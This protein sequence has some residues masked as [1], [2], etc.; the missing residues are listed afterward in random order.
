MTGA[1]VLSLLNAAVWA[2]V[3]AM[4]SLGLTLIYGQLSI[5]NIAHGAMY[6]IGAIST[7]YMTAFLGSWAYSLVA[8]PLIMAAV[9]VVIYLATLR[10][11]IIGYPM[12]TTLIISYGLMF[13]LE[14]TLFLIF[15][16]APRNIPN[17]LPFQVPLFGRTTY[18]GYRIFAAMFSLAIIGAL[19]TFLKKTKLGLWIRAT[20]QDHDTASAMGIP[21]PSVYMFTFVLGS[22]LAALGGVVVAPM[23]S[24]TPGMGHDILIDAFIIVIVA[25][26]GS[27]PGTILSALI[28]SLSNG[29][30]S[31]FFDP[32]LAKGMSLA[33]MVGVL[34]WR[35]EGIMRY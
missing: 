12:A 33:V 22:V 10:Y 20:S 9:A 23:T 25:G 24:I 29:I 11:R 2:C 32:V 7:F 19:V 34:Y 4:V 16:G 3:I 31:V 5:I 15:G 6:A 8:G 35:P 21:V 17:P 30:F 28:L 13:I 1:L 14:Q 18:S 26:F 27:I